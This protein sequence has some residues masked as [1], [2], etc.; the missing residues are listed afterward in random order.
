LIATCERE[1]ALLKP[2]IAKAPPFLAAA[3]QEFFV[4]PFAFAL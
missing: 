1:I 3:P 2:G 4:F